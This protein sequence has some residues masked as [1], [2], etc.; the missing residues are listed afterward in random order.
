M[1]FRKSNYCLQHKTSMQ[2]TKSS[3]KIDNQSISARLLTMGFSCISTLSDWLI[4]WSPSSAFSVI[5]CSQVYC[6]VQLTIPWLF[7]T[8]SMWVCT[9][10]AVLLLEGQPTLNNDVQLQWWTENWWINFESTLS[11]AGAMSCKCSAI[12]LMAAWSHWGFGQQTGEF[13]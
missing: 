7:E 12:I 1:Q 10:Q 2:S 5:I 3:T 9:M 11:V 13:S 8:R 4:S 6:W